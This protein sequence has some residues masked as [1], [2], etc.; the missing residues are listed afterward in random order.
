VL[1]IDYH[2]GQ[3]YPVLERVKSEADVLGEILK[4]MAAV[5]K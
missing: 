1:K 4:P 5:K 3:R 2:D